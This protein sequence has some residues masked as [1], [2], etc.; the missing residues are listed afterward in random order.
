MK[1]V[2][3]LGNVAEWVEC[4]GMTVL[5]KTETLN[6]CKPQLLESKDIFLTSKLR[7]VLILFSCCF[8]SVLTPSN[9]L[10]CKCI[11]Y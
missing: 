6:V 11:L 1:A 2:V 7:L 3:Y 10:R 8:V 5:G 4:P 9:L